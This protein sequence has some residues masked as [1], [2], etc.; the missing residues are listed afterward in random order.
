MIDHVEVVL[1]DDAI[2]MRVDEVLPRVVPQWPSSMRFTS[3]SASGRFSS[4][5]SN[6]KIWPTDR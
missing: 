5:L 3:A 6:R 1:D 2:E 4:G